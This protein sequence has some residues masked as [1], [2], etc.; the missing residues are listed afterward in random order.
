MK[1]QFTTTPLRAVTSTLLLLAVWF[2]CLNSSSALDSKSI[3]LT[4]VESQERLATLPLED[5]QV[6]LDAPYK[7]TSRHY[8]G[9]TLQAVLDAFQI[10]VP[11]GAALRFV[12]SDGYKSVV[13][14]AKYPLEPAFLASVT[15][16]RKAGISVKDISEGKGS[17][18]PA[19]FALVWRGT[20]QKEATPWPFGIVGIE[21]G[22]YKD[23]YGPAYPT[24]NL[25][26]LEGFKTFQSYCMSC[27]S[28][29]MQ[30]GIVGPELNVPKNVTEY[31][32]REHLQG[33]IENP[34]NY[35]FKS[36]MPA[37]GLP[38]KKIEEVYYYL[39]TIKEEKVCSTLEECQQ[40]DASQGADNE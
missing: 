28:V 7:A 11:E 10:K 18:D 13:D 8:K 26:A 20:A 4:S 19:P 34:Q 15:Q 27:H 25:A 32:S 24:G 30:G 21:V 2:L 17:V 1:E 12:C 29:N 33:F 22:S 5:I 6:M 14:P 9:F 23:L 38:V 16:T 3:D 31:W 36:R 35:R 37:L 39:E 40:W